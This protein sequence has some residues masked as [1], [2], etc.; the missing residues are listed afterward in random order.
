MATKRVA[1][2]GGSGNLGR[3]VID[4][5]LA[6]G[7]YGVVILSRGAQGADLPKGVAWRQVDYDDKSALVDAMNGIDTV[8]SFLA[9]LDQN[10]A[11]ELHKK[12]ID[13]AIEAGVRRFAPSEWATASNSG[14]A[15]YQYKDE[16]RKY[17]EEVN[18]NQQK[19]EYCLFQPGMFTDYFGHPKSTT[20]HFETFYMF[21]D[22]QNRRAIVPEDSEAPITLTIVRDMCRIVAQALEYDG[23]WP[24]VGG[25]QGTAFTVSELIT[26]G[27]KIRG[28]F[29]VEKISNEDLETRNVITSW[30]PLVEHHALP[31]EMREQVSK[32]VLVEY[33]A[34]LKRGVWTVSDE[35]NKLLPD[36][37]FTSAETYLKDIWL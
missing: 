27:E 6:R 17:L 9:M 36:F 11:L 22:F 28:P 23:V 8:L 4:E 37:E 29:K 5:I 26:L 13:A 30:Y 35:W 33:L 10:E 32:A 18:S 15:H 2:V 24:H 31:D 21:G 14:V 16:V 7:S 3:E 20:K 34:G 19:I 25:M 1:V 12:L